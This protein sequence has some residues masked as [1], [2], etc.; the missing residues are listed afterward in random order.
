[1]LGEYESKASNRRSLCDVISIP[2]ELPDAIACISAFQEEE[3][4]KSESLPFFQGCHQAAIGVQLYVNRVLAESAAISDYAKGGGH[5]P[6]IN[7]G[8]LREEIENQMNI[9]TY[10]YI[11]ILFPD[12]ILYE[13]VR[14]LYEQ[15]K[16][17]VEFTR[18]ILLTARNF[19]I[20]LSIRFNRFSNLYRFKEEYCRAYFDYHIFSSF[21]WHETD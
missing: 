4:L 18:D 21:F 8:K 5:C 20:D 19:A 12:R 14:D 10:L 9:I 13:H 1:L 17:S 7:V 11:D 16:K 2:N 15:Y 3:K 6:D